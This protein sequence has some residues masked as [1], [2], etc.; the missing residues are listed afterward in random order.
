MQNPENFHLPIK[1]E[2][3]ARTG[4]RR[5]TNV[6]NV[7]LAAAS[8]TAPRNELLPRLVVEEHPIAT[9]GGAVS[10]VRRLSVPQV[11]RVCKSLTAFGFVAPV[12]IDAES[13]IV[14]GQIVVEAARQLGLLTVPCVRL[15]HLSKSEL[16]LLRVT[17]NRLGET[18]EWNLDE[19]AIEFAD[20]AALE[21]D[22]SPTGFSLEEIDI[23]TSPGL[24]ANVEDE[25]ELPEPVGEPTSCVGDLWCLGR[26]R[27]LCADSLSPD[28]FQTLMAGARASAII[29]DKPYNVP[30]AGHVS[31]LGKK[32]HKEFAMASGEMSDAA[33][34]TFLLTSLTRCRENVVPGGVIYAFMDWRSIAPLVTSGQLAGLT[35][36][37]M[38][39]WNKGAGGMGSL[40]RSAHE[41]VAVFCNGATPARNNVQLGRHGRDRTNVW[42]FPGANRRGSSASKV[43]DGHPTPKP[44][45]LVG[46]AILDVTVAGDI[47]LDPFM[48]SGTTI[49][50]AER[51]RRIAYGVELDP[52]YVDLA[53]R[54][55]E[56][57]TGKEAVH[58]DTGLT[59]AAMT[60]QRLTGATTGTAISDSTEAQCN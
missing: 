9:L 49:I 13:R 33:F 18:G 3:A 47:V 25:A 26:H 46:D 36:V 41:L 14:D 29:S 42:N 1:T 51:N 17:L 15:S 32:T 45:E 55:W 16:R 28:T 44:V 39:V 53:V 4:R 59:F 57:E 37:N 31:G 52:Q 58:L 27:L 22:L 60:E 30:I 54:R 56:Q 7:A 35:L 5:R 43:L 20:L 2:L 8:S 34:A 40:Y 19:L 48:G 21:I 10:Q 23:I 11:T 38:A 12:I 6:T 50:A 24:P